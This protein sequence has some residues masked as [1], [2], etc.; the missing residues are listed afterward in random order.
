[1]GIGTWKTRFV[2]GTPTNS[3][4][5]EPEAAQ[6]VISAP[7]APGLI[8]DIGIDQIHELPP[9]EA[10]P[11]R[12]PRGVVALDGEREIEFSPDDKLAVRLEWDGP[13]T[14]DIRGVMAYAAQNALLTRM[15]DTSRH[16]KR[17]GD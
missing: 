10:V 4:S 14:L 1:M 17:L 5:A 16:A 11:I 13:L 9:G 15:G 8:V 12:V 2:L 6:K 3:S 7:L